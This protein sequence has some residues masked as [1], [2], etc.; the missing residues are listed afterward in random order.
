[1]VLYVL[2]EE[3]IK[4]FRCLFELSFKLVSG[5][6]KQ[7]KCKIN[8]KKTNLQCVFVCNA[9][10]KIVFC[11]SYNVRRCW[12]TRRIHQSHQLLEGFS[13]DE[14]YWFQ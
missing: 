5:P 11:F 6:L 8:A 12:V 10:T 1:M 2:P 7:F 4:V 3:E 13:E 9:T 14:S